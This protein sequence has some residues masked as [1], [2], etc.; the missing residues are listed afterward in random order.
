MALER[1]R[2]QERERE[3]EL[4][5]SA[6][7]TVELEWARLERAEE[8]ESMW[9]KGT[10]GL[11]VLEKVTGVLARLDRAGKAAEVVEEM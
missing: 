10:E 6:G 8:V 1:E 2:E 7:Q 9:Q 3:L 5:R 4:E 11:V